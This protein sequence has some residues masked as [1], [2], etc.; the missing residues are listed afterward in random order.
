MR[1][2][3]FANFYT[4]TSGGLRTCVEETGR[5]YTERGHDRLLVVPG[6]A[7]ADE[8]TASGRRV[9]IASPSMFGSDE[10]RMVT[11]HRR[12]LR[13][14]DGFG[15]DVLEVSDKLAVAW[16]SPWARRRGVPLVL[17]SHERVDAVLGARIRF[18]RTS[19]LHRCADAMNRALRRRVDRV[20]CASAFSAA[21]FE[22][23]VRSSW[24][25]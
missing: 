11:A 16:L 2:A 9:A 21:E 4:P 14:L 5:G 3:Q 19:A 24:C 22:R 15:P 6:R 8:C 7:D 18:A 10:Y 17:F 12:V 20:V 13:L 1:I 25:W 23:A